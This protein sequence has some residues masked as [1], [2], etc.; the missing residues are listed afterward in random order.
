MA[1]I[2]EELGI[3]YVLTTEVI[4]WACGAVRELDLARQ[5]MYYA[6]QNKI[7]PK[8]L[9]DGL[10]TIKDPPFESFRENEL[11]AMQAKIRDDHYRIFTDSG[12][13]YVFNNHSFI[14]DTDIQAI[15]N[16]L[17]IK[18]AEHAFYMGRELQKAVL[19]VRLGKKYVQEE[20]LRW[21]YM[22]H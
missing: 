10:L 21:G 14:K 4:S 15:F 6:C 20:E 12:F 19:A 7:L 1:G 2:V 11:H 13:I 16:R 9:N 22:G 3:D 18:D 5:L 17:D 8:H